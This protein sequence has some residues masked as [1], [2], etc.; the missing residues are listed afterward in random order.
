MTPLLRNIPNVLTAVRV[1]LAPDGFAFSFAAFLSFKSCSTAE[2]NFSAYTA[3]N[4]SYHWEAV[5]IGS[6]HYLYFMRG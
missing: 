4:V 5:F 6:A 3:M 1:V 2:Y